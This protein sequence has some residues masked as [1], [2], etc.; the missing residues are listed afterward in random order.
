MVVPAR[1]GTA[2]ASSGSKETIPR[3][4]R[5]VLQ[6]KGP[7]FNRMGRRPSLEYTEQGFGLL[8]S[9]GIPRERSAEMEYKHVNGPVYCRFALTPPIINS[10]RAHE[11]GIEAPSMIDLHA[12]SNISLKEGSNVK[13]R[14][15]L[16]NRSKRITCHAQIDHM[17]RDEA[18]GETKVGFSHLSLSDEEF[19]VLMENFC[20]EPVGKLEVAERVEDKGTEAKPVTEAELF[21][22]TTRIK[23]VTLSVNLIEE[24]DAKRGEVP[25]SEFVSRAISAYLEG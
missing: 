25:F 1:K 20:D 16:D 2:P 12:G 15:L 23:A 8:L 3:H 17:V 18:G 22:G 10:L 4:R 5:R 14:M 13:L 19:G 11:Y 24:I 6:N 7:R 9:A 21:L